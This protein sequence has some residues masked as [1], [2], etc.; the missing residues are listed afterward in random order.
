[1][2]AAS[3]FRVAADAPVARLSDKV[4]VPSPVA[5]PGPDTAP[6]EEAY[7]VRAPLESDDR[8]FS[9]GPFYG[10]P[11]VPPPIRGRRR[12]RIRS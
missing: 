8:T 6:V 12:V 10:G 3:A 7:E 1:Q 4:V 2:E 11:F 9:Y 5:P